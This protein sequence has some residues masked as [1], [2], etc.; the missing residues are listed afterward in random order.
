MK[1]KTEP[2]VLNNMLVLNLDVNIWSARRKLRPEDFQH[3]QLPPEHL[4][5]LGSKK[6]A[7]PNDLK[8]FGTLKSR[9]V[10]LLDKQGVRFL[11]GWAIPQDSA[12]MI[13]NG[14]QQIADEFYSAKADF[15][16]N[17]GESVQKWINSNPG[18]EKIIARSAVSAGYVD[19]RI[20]FSWQTFK[21]VSPST[22]D[23][24]LQT[25][26][27]TEVEHLGSTLFDEVAKV[28]REAWS[29]SYEAK[30][31]IT[32]KALRPLQTIMN[33]MEGLNFIEPRVMPVAELIQS[34]ISKLPSRG[35]IRGTDL[36]MLKQLVTLLA[37]PKQIV[38]YAQE[39]IDGRSNDN[40][41]GSLITTEKKS[42]K[43]P[44]SRKSPVAKPQTVPQLESHGLW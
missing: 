11:G 10:S 24:R 41:L 34:A 36:L 4:V 43:K 26:L 6:I 5:S 2:K 35:A 15:M 19:S 28:A 17:Y 3:A 20:G 40:V 22:A 14:L 39:I 18:Y 16:Q 42:A 32:R 38:Q 31:E 12:S 37:S 21:V 30:T 33:K 44:K 9:A 1:L 29:K 7:N 25:G 23:D 13:N 8:I 27:H